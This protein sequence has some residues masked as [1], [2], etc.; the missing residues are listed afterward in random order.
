MNITMLTLMLASL[1]ATPAAENPVFNELLERGVIM[2]DGTALKLKP[3]ILPDGLNAAEQR[4]A[5]AKVAD[6][7]A[8]V[9]E[10]LAKTAMAP[11]VT[12]VRTANASEGEG[13]AV[14]TVDV[15]FVAHGDWNTLNSKEFADSIIAAE[16]NKSKR[17]IVTKS[18]FLTD[19]EI[20]KRK[21]AAKITDGHE[22]RFLYTTFSLFE[23]VQVS[24]TRFSVVTKDGNTVLAAGKL[25]SRFD[26]DADYPNQWRPLVRDVQAEVKPGPAHRFSHAGG[27]AKIT[28]LKEPAN[29]VFVECHLVYEEPYAWFEGANLV[30]QKL[31][32]MVREK[33]RAF[34]RKLAAAD[35]EKA[36]TTQKP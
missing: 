5:I 18:G 1:A 17:S 20:Q 16:G 36:E 30:Q 23:L 6:A 11:V 15:W 8:P 9:H 22:E 13:P 14:R 27:Y 7:R 35:K 3:P 29:A 2:S 24:A 19:D 21:L 12:K 4:A 34:R 25:D 31:P 26:K 10:L 33:V 28:R 32:V